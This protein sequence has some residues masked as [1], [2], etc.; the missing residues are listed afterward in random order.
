MFLNP[1]NP[2]IIE[3]AV[4]GEDSHLAKER[5]ATKTAELEALI[6]E[7]EDNGE[8]AATISAMIEQWELENA[9]STRDT[10]VEQCAEQ[11]AEDELAKEERKFGNSN[12]HITGE[13]I[14][15]ANTGGDYSQIHPLQG[16]FS[17][18]YFGGRDDLGDNSIIP[19]LQAVYGDDYEITNP[20]SWNESVR[21]TNKRTNKSNTF[22]LSHYQM[23]G[24]LD[25]HGE[26][27]EG[28]K[29]LGIGVKKQANYLA[30]DIA[31]GS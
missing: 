1:I 29:P 25:E 30:E 16:I 26:K 4:R 14:D 5:R 19:A 7:A 15:T 11:Q 28:V 21:F 27:R 3:D 8:D 12:Q 2:L 9:G 6:K 13:E 22:Q 31:A 18:T 24:G 10:R 17:G 20:S 23:A